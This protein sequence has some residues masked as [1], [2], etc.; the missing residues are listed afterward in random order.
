VVSKLAKPTDET[1]AISGTITVDE[2][3]VRLEGVEVTTGRQT[4]TTDPMGNYFLARLDPGKHTVRMQ[5]IGFEPVE[6]MIDVTRG[7]NSVVDLVMKAKLRRRLTGV[8]LA[9]DGPP[10]PLA[11]VKVRIEPADRTTV[12]DNQGRYTFEECIPAPYTLIASADG[13][14]SYEAKNVVVEMMGPSRHDFFMGRRPEG[15][16]HT[17]MASN[18]SMEAGGGGGGQDWIALGF[19]PLMIDPALSKASVRL[20]EVAD[21]DAHTGQR[22]QVMRMFDKETVIRQITHYGTARPGTRYRG[23]VWI[24]TDCP[25]GSEAWITF[26]ATDNGGGVVGRIGPSERISGATG[27][28][29]ISLEAVAPPG[30][31][32]LSLNFHTQGERGIACFDDA[33]IGPAETADES[34]KK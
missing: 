18:P 6:R 7:E 22:C 26:D 14:Y 27:W 21:R 5:K 12:T 1:G 17:N 15:L 34:E 9:G 8:V 2:L 13:C 4:F 33:F 19:E 31:Q 32:R 3:G 29:W 11:G 23:G 24:R 20:G 28:K 25:A 30:S 10:R 16:P